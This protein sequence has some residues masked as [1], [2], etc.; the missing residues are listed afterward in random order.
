MICFHCRTSRNRARMM[1]SISVMIADTVFSLVVESI[2]LVQGKLC[3]F[4]PIELVGQTVNLFHLCL[5]NSLYCFEYK[6]FSQGLELHRRLAYIEQNWPYFLGFGLPLAILTSMP[7]SLIVSGCVFSILFP[8]FIV[9]GNQAQVVMSEHDITVNIFH[10]TIFISNWI[11]SKT[12]KN[13]KQ[14]QQPQ[15]QQSQDR[16]IRRVQFEWSFLLFYGCDIAQK[17]F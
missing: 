9:S 12:F 4:L 11:F 1:S 16:M 15:Q 3:S 7:D 8:L 10:P 17:S 6:W 14:Q 13:K 5:L 2:F